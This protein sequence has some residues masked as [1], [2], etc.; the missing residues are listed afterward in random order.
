MGRTVDARD[1]VDRRVV[2]NVRN[3][4][5]KILTS[6]EQ[7][8]GWPVLEAGT[9]PLD[10]DRDGMPDQWE[11]LHDLPSSTPASLTADQDGDGYTDI[12][13]YLNGSNPRLADAP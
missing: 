13:E 5:G 12:E 8:P 7:F 6:P 3:G 9:P 2:D 4:T 10:G 1:A 11:Q